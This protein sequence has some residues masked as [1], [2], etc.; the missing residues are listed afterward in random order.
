[1]LVKALIVEQLDSD[2][3]LRSFLMEPGGYRE[4]II[5][6]FPDEYEEERSGPFHFLRPEDAKLFTAGFAE[7]KARRLGRA[8]FQR[9]DDE[10]NVE[11]SWA[12]IPTERQSLS[13]YALSLPEHGIPVELSVSDPHHPGREYRRAVT[14]DDRR[15]RFVVYVNCTSSVGRFDFAF[16]CRLRIDPS[17]FSVA[18][19]SDP[20]VQQHGGYPDHGLE[21]LPR[22]QRGEVANFFVNELRMGDHYSAQQAGAMGPHARADRNTFQQVSG[23]GLGIDYKQLARELMKL[24]DAMAKEASDPIHTKA[25]ESVEAA[26]QSAALGDSQGVTSSLKKAGTWSIDVATKIGVGLATAAI[27]SAMG[28]P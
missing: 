23:S 5:V 28:L 10:I 11:L 24:R 7:C 27:K 3:G 22:N 6:A 2:G 12:G 4:N 13:Y 20:F 18:S 16:R 25:I 14:R 19:Y 15:Q 9:I 17:Q 1:M 26:Q 21:L 8:N